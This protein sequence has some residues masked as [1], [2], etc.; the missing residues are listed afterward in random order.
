M[1]RDGKVDANLGACTCHHRDD[2]ACAEC[3][4]PFGKCEAIAVHHQLERITDI[5]KIIERLTH[6][7]HHDVGEHP[8]ILRAWPFTERIAREHHLPNDFARRQVAHQ[9]HR[10]S[11]AKAAVERAA[12]LARY[13]ERPAIRIRNENHL[14][15]LS[16]R[17]TQQPFAC[18]V[19]GDLRFNHFGSANHEMLGK[20]RVHRLGDVSH[21]RKLS[22]AAIIHPMPK[23]FRAQLGLLWLHTSGFEARADFSLGQADQVSTAILTR[24]GGTGHGDGIN[25]AGDLHG[26]N[27]AER[28]EVSGRAS[29]PPGKL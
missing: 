9:P 2:A 18:T 12:D 21:Q 17:R 1:E 5:V 11:V 7:H 10:T 25:M 16:I 15:I 13:T 19:R 23:L 28:E 8:P 4:P 20:P 14:I 26:A 3:N 22:H 6:P 24:G 27:E 29:Y